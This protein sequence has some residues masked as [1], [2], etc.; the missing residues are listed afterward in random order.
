MAT[1]AASGPTSQL[2][3]PKAGAGHSKSRPKRGRVARTKGVSMLPEELEAVSAVEELTGLGFSELYHRH[4]A[5]Q[6]QAA[7]E[8]LHEVQDAGVELNR[9]TLRDTWVIHMSQEELAAVYSAGSSFV[10]GD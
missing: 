2:Q 6:V 8:M 7:V 4:F 5:P 1:I 10:L 9:A 3:Q